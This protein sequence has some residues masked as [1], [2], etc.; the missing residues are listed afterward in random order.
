MPDRVV[1]RT[2][3][4]LRERLRSSFFDEDGLRRLCLGQI[5]PR[6][7]ARVLDIGCGTGALARVL[8]EACPATEIVGVDADPNVLRIAAEEACGR[9]LGVRFRLGRVENLRFAPGTFD[10][11]AASLVFHHLEPAHRDAT[12]RR[13]RRWLRP[14]GELHVA[15]WTQPA[16]RNR[17]R[18]LEAGLGFPRP[19]GTS[20]QAAG[21]LEAYFERAGFAW[22]E[23]GRFETSLGT[24]TTYRVR[25]R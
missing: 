6:P 14:G 9:G 23:T 16:T 22:E 25:A 21:P 4:P 17:G 10:A 5:A 2:V 12:L 13:V 19:G 11:V 20:F 7:G 3:T 1:A 24:I 8:K 18:F 15:D